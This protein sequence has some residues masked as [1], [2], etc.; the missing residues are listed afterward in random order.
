VAEDD[1]LDRPRPLAAAV[2]YQ[3]GSVV[4]RTLLKR[5][6]LTLTAFAFDRGQSLSPHTVPHDAVVQVLE[7]AAEITVG[8]RAHR[9]AAGETLRMPGGVEHA[10]EAV[11]PFKML[12]TLLRA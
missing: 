10:V 2:D 6:A 8:G 4:S 11:E 5:P 1:Y 7:G 3:T 12:L 9:V